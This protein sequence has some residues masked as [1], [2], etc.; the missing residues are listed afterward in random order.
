ML[1]DLKCVFN[2]GYK[3]EIIVFYYFSYEF[4]SNY[5]IYIHKY[6][7]VNLKEPAYS[8]QRLET[9]Y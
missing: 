8:Q 9:R 6:R 7:S 2:K 4:N 3:K 5:L 1:P